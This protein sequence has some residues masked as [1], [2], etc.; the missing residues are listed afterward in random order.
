MI[1]FLINIL[2]LLSSL[3]ANILTGLDV[4]EQQDFKLLHDKNIGLVINHTSVNKEEIHILDLLLN[5]K[6]MNVVSIFTPEHGLKGNFSAGEKVDYDSNQDFGIKIV[7]LYGNKKEPNL[8]D[9]EDIDCI[10]FDIQD[11][12]SRYYTYVSTLTYMLNASALYDIP[13]IVL[14]RPNPLG[15]HVEGPIISSDFYS[16]VGMHPIPIRHGMTIGELAQMI[17]GENWIDSKKRANLKVIKLDGWDT[18]PGYFSKP[19]SPNMPDFET[20]LIY[21]GACLFEGTNIS[22]GRG[23]KD[24][25][26]L[27]G[28]PWMDSN[29]ILEDLIELDYKGVSFYQKTFKPQSI[30]GARYPKYKNQLCYGIRM[31]V[32][33]QSEIKPLEIS[34]SILKI[35][36]KYHGDNFSFN[37]NNFIEKLYGSDV[38][39][40]NIKDKSSIQDLINTWDKDSET[41]ISQREPYLLY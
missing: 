39:K 7:S 15:R 28:A 27:F 21:N 37:N 25:F 16:F 24:P 36:Y 19:P 2:F 20:A 38:I 9:L 32:L 3:D 14:D 41:F 22:E 34:I 13:I 12:G 31:N 30:D 17:N 10:V 1:T 6:N 18:K 40:D 8:N 29:L 4:V 23:T 33:N 5:N 26:L 35:I 11:I